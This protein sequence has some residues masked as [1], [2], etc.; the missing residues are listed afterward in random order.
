VARKVAA[1][2]S[3]RTKKRN[4]RKDCQD[5]RE[6]EGSKTLRRKLLPKF[7]EDPC[8]GCAPKAAVVAA[9]KPAKPVAAAPRVEE[10]KKVVTSV[11]ASSNEF[12]VYP[13]TAWPIWP[14]RS[15]RSGA[16]LELFVIIS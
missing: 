2:K 1:T 13:A 8:E 6:S 12:V 3:S 10:P 16:K 9:P 5:C 4:A 7:R 11:R 14:S 15:R